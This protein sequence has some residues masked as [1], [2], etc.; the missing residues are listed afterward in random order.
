MKNLLIILTLLFI[1]SCG[2]NKKITKQEQQYRVYK[3]DSINSY[4]L[5]YATLN[6]SIFK[7]VSKK[8]YITDCK[9]IKIGSNY[10]F[11]LK[12]MRENA[13]TIGNLKISPINHIDI[14]CFQF[15]ENTQI[16]KEEGVY[17][18]YFADNLK[19]L[20]FIND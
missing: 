11:K 19:G 5:I 18:L 9:K 4:Y 15:D 1:A 7:I 6:D 12:S 17:D 13:P 16:C 20:C 14:K 8:D 3:L 10:F 2:T